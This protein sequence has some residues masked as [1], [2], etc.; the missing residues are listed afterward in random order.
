MLPEPARAASS[1]ARVVRVGRSGSTNAEL[2]ESLRRGDPVD[3]AWPHLGVLVADHQAAGRGRAGR[4]WVT[5]P[6][7]ALTAS[8]VLRTDVPVDRWS[9]LG[10]LGGLA[11][12]RAVRAST[13]LP[14][15]LKWPNDVVLR[16]VGARIEPGWGRDRKVA[17]VLAQVVP[18]PEGPP[19]AVLG[20]GVNVHQQG[21]DLPVRWATSLAAAGV[22][23]EARGRDALLEAVGRELA[24]LEARWRAAGGDAV[25][26]GLAAEV[27]SACGTLG[28]DVRVVLPGGGEIAGRAARLGPDGAL[29]V[30]PSSGPEVVV[31][32]GD[33]DHVRTFGSG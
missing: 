11:V 8:V 23:E 26:A 14:A 33:V 27:A 29:V 5:P 4:G 32:A 18:I 9:W 10:L 22:P 17:G 19:A 21:V 31:T 13:S 25:V 15:E 7:T 3:G 28:R 12:V 30:R 1:F 2:A 24:P 16:G 20:F 6:G